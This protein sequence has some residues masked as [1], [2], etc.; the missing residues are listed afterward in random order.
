MEIYKYTGS[1]AGRLNNLLRKGIY[2]R[3]RLYLL[4]E[5]NCLPPMNSAL[6][7]RGFRR[8]HLS[9]VLKEYKGE[10]YFKDKAFLSCTSDEEVAR[11]Y[12]GGEDRVVLV[13]ETKPQGSGARDISQ[14][15]RFKDGEAA[16]WEVL[17]PPNAVF[18]VCGKREEG[19]LLQL[20][21]KEL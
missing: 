3:G 20:F 21:A 12:S 15:S 9:K 18:K 1:Y 7:Y 19:N 11:D 13:I 6:V 17:F 4:R 5:L 2:P 10:F 16:E 8:V 14:L